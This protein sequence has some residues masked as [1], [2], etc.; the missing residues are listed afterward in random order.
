MKTL[1]KN[2]ILL[3]GLLLLTLPEIAN[4]QPNFAR[5]TGKSCT[6]CHA[7]NMPKLNAYGRNFALSGY[8]MYD[9]VN[10]TQS[11]IEGSE[12]ELGMPEVLNASMIIK[13]KYT[14]IES[15][16]GELNVLDGSG[17][18]LGGR[19]ANNVGALISLSGDESSGNDVVFDGKVVL[20]YETLNGF[21]GL[22][23]YSTHNNGIFSGMENFNTGLYSPL[24]QFE[25]ASSTNAAQATAIGR[26]EATGLQAYYGDGNFFA[27]VGVTVPSQNS[28]GIDAGGSLIPFARIAYTQPI[29]SWNFTLGA[30]GFSGDVE[31]S[32]QSLNGGLIDSHANLVTVDKE[33]YGID[34]EATGTIADMATIT[35]VNVVLKNVI[36]TDGNVTN[37]SGDHL[38][39]TDNEAASIEFQINP[40]AALG[41]K[42]AYL[43]YQN[44]LADSLNNSYIKYYDYKA[45]SIGL[46]YLFSQNVIVDLQYTQNYTDETSIVDDFNEI[47]LS[48]II[49]F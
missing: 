2:F 14:K 36:T 34:F 42:V 39:H 9:A 37:L 32:D 35:T 38:Q 45:S 3:S 31:A 33:G 10:E 17:L 16:R 15:Q 22:S 44:N 5:Q 8:T 27:T 13:A 41:I 40:I 18:Y 30:Y 29:G 4:A 11:L 23:L 24:K 7:Q 28:E 6:A 25:N 12:P 49:A 46:S 47:Y 20:S 1:T 48:A 19:V 43:S 21:S 26:G